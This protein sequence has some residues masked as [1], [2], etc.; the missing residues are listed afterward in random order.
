LPEEVKRALNTVRN[1]TK[2]MRTIPIQSTC[3]LKDGPQCMWKC[4][5]QQ[6]QQKGGYTGAQDNDADGA[7]ENLRI[8]RLSNGGKQN[9]LYN[10][11]DQTEGGL[12]FALACR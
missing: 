3:Q 10:K 5:P 2:Y 4:M 11:T 9:I 8:K 1:E 7:G 12:V 6:Q